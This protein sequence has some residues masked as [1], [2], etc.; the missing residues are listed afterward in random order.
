MSRLPFES[1]NIQAAVSPI[2]SRSSRELLN[3][4]S[5]PS[6]PILDLPMADAL[7]RDIEQYYYYGLPSCPR[8]VASSIARDWVPPDT[9]PRSKHIFPPSLNHPISSIWETH[10]VPAQCK[11][12]DELARGAVCF[13]FVRIGELQEDAPNILWIGVAP[14]S[15]SSEAGV[16]VIRSSQA[17]LFANGIADVA[18]EIR[19]TNI[20][21]LTEP[22]L[23][24]ATSWSSTATR[25]AD[26]FC[27]SIGTPISS[28]DTPHS[29]G[30]GGI[31]LHGS[32]E[33]EANLLLTA[34]HVLATSAANSL[35]P[36][37]LLGPEVSIYDN[38]SYQ[39]HLGNLQ[40]S[41]VSAKA[42]MD[43]YSEQMSTE[44]GD[45]LLEA[46]QK[47]DRASA[48]YNALTKLKEVLVRDWSRKEKQVLGHVFAYPPRAPHVGE[49]EYTE[50]WGLILVSHEKSGHQRLPNELNLRDD[51][52]R[53]LARGHLHL[54]PQLAS[55][56]PGDVLPISGV[57]PRRELTAGELAVL[58][59]GATTGLSVGVTWSP[60]SFVRLDFDNAWTRELPI[61]TVVA[62]RGE[63][64]VPPFSG[65]G[66]S[67]ATVIDRSGRVCGILTAGA[68]NAQGVDITYATPMWWLLERMRGFG[69]NVED[70]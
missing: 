1:P 49:Y 48:E 28:R 44:T 65:R 16:E 54:E 58:K 43:N 59:R 20:E 40:D 30:T 67:G 3:D 5:V 45:L 12:L 26:P 66:D 15:M 29:L 6:I 52:D 53:S 37:T 55:L 21:L 36:N 33:R 9:H 2:S 61:V 19:E 38:A 4:R 27:S 8:L 11:A 35:R 23:L 56:R 24:D 41:I 51:R 18:V 25:Y 34:G 64:F 63:H 70:P 14:G 60:Q 22:A 31:Y 68:L 17:I 46:G 7:P 13:D 42:E 32:N 10:I 39:R 62:R 47:W 50:D 57:V 69:L